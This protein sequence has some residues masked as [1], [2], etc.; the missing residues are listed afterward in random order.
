MINSKYF[1][2]ELFENQATLKETSYDDD[3]K[4]YMVEYTDLVIDFDK[5]K[6]NYCE[7]YGS[8]KEA[9]KSADALV[10]NK[11]GKIVFIEF[12]NGQLKGKTSGLKSK[13][14]DS[15]LIFC[16][17]NGLNLKFT[18]ENIEYI[19][20]YND[21]KN[22]NSVEDQK[23]KIKEG[24]PEIQGLLAGLANEEFVYFGLWVLK[25]VFISDVHTYTVEEF[26]KYYQESLK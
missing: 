9:S 23:K 13:L 3:K 16:D 21:S 15:L 10:V 5:V 17:I 6:E 22:K 20:V 25:K 26:D 1:E 24:L 8:H 14:R 19:L 18:R 7:K 12:K 11:N 2:H 4:E